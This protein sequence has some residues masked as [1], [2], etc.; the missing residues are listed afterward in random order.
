MSLITG[1]DLASK[2]EMYDNEDDVQ[3]DVKERSEECCAKH[4]D[5]S[6]TT[7]LHKKKNMLPRRDREWTTPLSSMA[8]SPGKGDMASFV[9]RPDMDVNRKCMDKNGNRKCYKMSNRLS[10]TEKPSQDYDNF[11]CCQNEM[12]EYT[13]YTDEVSPYE[14]I[15]GIDSWSS[16]RGGVDTSEK[17]EYLQN[18]SCVGNED[19]T[20]E[21][22]QPHKLETVFELQVGVF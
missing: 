19:E 12:V 16:R 5:F 8:E 10:P 13:H 4:P 9:E 17:E 11:Q 20:L 14:V 6:N 1:P 3:F 21:V 18:W 22:Y 15:F 2:M 7:F